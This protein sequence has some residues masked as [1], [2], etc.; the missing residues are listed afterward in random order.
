MVSAAET[1]V[2][3]SP[4]SCAAVFRH[5]LRSPLSFSRSLLLGGS[6][7][8]LP[9]LLGIF[10]ASRSV[11]CACC[12]AVHTALG[13]PPGGPGDGSVPAGE[14]SARVVLVLARHPYTAAFASIC[15]HVGDLI[16]D[17]VTMWW[18]GWWELK[19][20]SGGLFFLR[21]RRLLTSGLLVLSLVVQWYLPMGQMFI[22]FGGPADV[23]GVQNSSTNH[24][25]TDY[26]SQGGCFSRGISA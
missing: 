14:M 13:P 5:V 22:V 1:Y 15:E 24:R 6:R 8:A 9:S 4:S 26:S 20:V 25:D 7:S 16:L 23:F 2:F 10:S 21:K 12:C 3:P 11:D 18:W 17:E 19:F